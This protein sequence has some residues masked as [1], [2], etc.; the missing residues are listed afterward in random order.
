MSSGDAM[1]S[2][3]I[4]ETCADNLFYILKCGSFSYNKF[5]SSFYQGQNV[6]V[7]EYVSFSG[8]R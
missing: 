3:Y 5:M 7:I 1:T 2:F 8:S 4:G 6:Y